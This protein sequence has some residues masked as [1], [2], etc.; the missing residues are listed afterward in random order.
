MVL[1]SILTSVFCVCIG[2]VG[3]EK[4][5]VVFCPKD[6]AILTI[7][8]SQVRGGFFTPFLLG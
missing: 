3:S 5:E 6:A 2:E 1:E 8:G 7:W 4:V